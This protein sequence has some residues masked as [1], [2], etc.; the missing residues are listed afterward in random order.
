MFKELLST[1]VLTTA[2]STPSLAQSTLETVRERG[3]MICGASANNPGFGA[4][5]EN[6]YYRG[7]DIETCRAVAV[8]TLG[9]KDAIE[10]VPLTGQQR[11]PALQTGEIDML[12]R[13]MTWTLQRDSNGINFTTPEL[14]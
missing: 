14:L 4:P 12:P 3:N 2:L 13:T 11:I 5:D 10:F 8:A 9:D 7:L 1:A 6:G